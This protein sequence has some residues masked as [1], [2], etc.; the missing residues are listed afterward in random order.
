MFRTLLTTL[1]HEDELREV[2][3]EGNTRSYIIKMKHWLLFFFQSTNGLRFDGDLANGRG[4]HFWFLRKTV[5]ES[6]MFWIL[7]G[8]FLIGLLLHRSNPNIKL[9]IKTS[10]IPPF[11][12]VFLRNQKCGP[13]P[14]VRSPSRCSSERFFFVLSLLWRVKVCEHY[15]VETYALES[16]IVTWAFSIPVFWK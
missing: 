9:P 11:K 10:N 1:L 6:W 14:L 16:V 5:L 8:S 12:T 3:H 4:P 7:T 15:Y 2:L 13:R